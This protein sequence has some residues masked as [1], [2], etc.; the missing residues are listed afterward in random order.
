[1]SINLKIQ[2][3]EAVWQ[4]IEEH[5]NVDRKEP[6]ILIAKKPMSG[7]SI[8]KVADELSE[9]IEQLLMVL[10]ASNNSPS[11]EEEE[12]ASSGDVVYTQQKVDEL[13][14][15]DLDTF[16]LGTVGGYFDFPF[17]DEEELI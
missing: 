11:K 4:I 3:R 2:L 14:D 7:N 12:Y 15:Q 16:G 10:E 17:D 6:T 9:T 8:D 13:E 1:M 5:Y